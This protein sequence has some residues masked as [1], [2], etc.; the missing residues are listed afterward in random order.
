MKAAVVDDRHGLHVVDLPDPTPGPGDLVLSVRA[1]GI[2][3][4]DLKTVGVMPAGLVMGH[5]FCGEV[6]AAGADVAGAWP[7]GRLVSALPLVGCGRCRWCLGGEPTHCETV[8][9]IGVGGSAGA[10]AEFVRVDAA[11][12]IA[13]PH[14]VG[15][16]GALIEPLAVGLHTVVAAELD[17]G[18]R[19]LVVGAGPVGLAV[20]TWARRLGAGDIVVS[21][22]VPAR[23][24]G[25]SSFGASAVVDPSTDELGSGY[26]VVFECVGA[27]GLI[28]SAVGVIR[29]Q[30]RVVV[31]GVCLVPDQLGPGLPL[32][33]EATVRWVMYYTRAEFELAARMIA[34]GDIDAGSFVTGRTALDGIDAAFADLKGGSTQHRKVLVVP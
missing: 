12:S 25:A 11:Q 30:G 2:C 13:L 16:L 20:S 5:E 10:F 27:A 3:G 8:D 34:A 26:D 21:D 19:V 31:A 33:R 9:R 29:P 15:D 17:P 18:D 32:I 22:P 28:E 23:R 7:E 1:C 14:D 24:A 6:V 4:S